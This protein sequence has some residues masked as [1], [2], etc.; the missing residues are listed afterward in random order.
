[1]KNP[2]K[3]TA[4]YGM[5]IALAFVL[6]FAE[7]LIPISLGLPGVK[8]GLANLVTVAG[9]YTVGIRGTIF[10]SLARILLAGFTFGN[11]F[12]MMYSLGGWSLSLFLMLLAQKRGWFHASGISI[13]G[14]IGHN[15]GQIC[16]AAA[17]VKQAAVFVY[18]PVLL[19][20]GTIAGLVIGIIGGMIVDRIGKFTK[21]LQ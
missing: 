4:L 14:G 15:I 18:L 12:S 21:K 5:L 9:L 20:S 8:L 19:L 10:I 3:R 2:A 7:T 11:V 16:V 13:L 6:S 1:M 17:V